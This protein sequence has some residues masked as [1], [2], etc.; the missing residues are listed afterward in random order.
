MKK[1]KFLLIPRSNNFQDTIQIFFIGKEL[2]IKG[3][4]VKKLTAPLFDKNLS[5]I[6]D[7]YSF[8][9]IFRIGAGKTVLVK[10]IQD[11]FHGQRALMTF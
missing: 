9:V 1:L 7:E 4:Y 6:V 11:L 10:K 5:S 8:D 2:S 3:H